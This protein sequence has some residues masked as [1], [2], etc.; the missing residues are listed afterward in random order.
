MESQKSITVCLADWGAVL[1]DLCELINSPFSIESFEKIEL[2]FINS[3]KKEL[4]FT[5]LGENNSKLL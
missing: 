3:I 5:C 2:D 4:N 1:P